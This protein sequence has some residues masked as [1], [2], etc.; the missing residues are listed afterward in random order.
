MALFASNVDDDK[1]P[2]LHR[3]EY[4]AKNR[5][6]DILCFY[7]DVYHN[8]TKLDAKVRELLKISKQRNSASA[9]ATITP[10]FRDKATGMCLPSQF[11]P[12][13]TSGFGSK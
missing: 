2:S 5:E 9:W 8:K 1:K 4:V 7:N 10:L 3:L 13:T 6:G 11:E 12:V